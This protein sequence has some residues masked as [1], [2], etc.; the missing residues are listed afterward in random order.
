MADDVKSRFASSGLWDDV[1][2][3]IID[4]LDDSMPDLALSYPPDLRGMAPRSRSMVVEAK[5]SV[6]SE[7]RGHYVH[8]PEV[9]VAISE[10]IEDI[11]NRYIIGKMIGRNLV[12]QSGRTIALQGERIT[13]QIIR[14]A[15]T[16]GLLVDLIEHMMFDSFED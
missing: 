2:P 8:L 3:F 13:Q 5:E 15:E 9:A 4:L 1:E 16:A 7:E 14:E 11:K 10:D 6:D 12:A